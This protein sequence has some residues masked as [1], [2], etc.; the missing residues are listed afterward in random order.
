MVIVWKGT[1]IYIFMISRFACLRFDFRATQ[2]TYF[3]QPLDPV[4][5][6]FLLLYLRLN[7]I[8]GSYNKELEMQIVCYHS[9]SQREQAKEIYQAPTGIFFHSLN[10]YCTTKSGNNI[11]DAQLRFSPC[12]QHSKPKI[13]E[14]NHNSE[15]V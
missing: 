11:G 6:I 14:R 8:S 13:T 15:N 9:S 2:P 12:S 4:F 1:L 10:R 7:I 5:T 3:H